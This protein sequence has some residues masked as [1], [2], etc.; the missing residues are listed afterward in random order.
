MDCLSDQTIARYVKAE[1]DAETSSLVEEHIDS[2]AS[3]RIAIAEAAR[4]GTLSSRTPLAI[5]ATLEEGPQTRL[6]IAAT[7]EEGPQT[8]SPTP[9]APSLSPGAQLGRYI[10]RRV[11]G[12]GAMG[13][14]YAAYDPNLERE[15]ALKLLRPEL[16]GPADARGLPER[17]L[18]EAKLM[19][20]LTHP[21]VISVYDVGVLDGQVFVA[22]ELVV[23]ETLRET[24]RK[25]RDLGQRSVKDVLALF[26]AAG[27]GLSA[28][29]R[30]HVV[31]R[32][33]KP[34]NVL[35]SQD[36]RV[37]VT[38]F[39]L[40]RVLRSED[41]G[42]GQAAPADPLR[43]SATHLTRTGAIVGT[44]AYMAPEQLH[45]QSA[46]ERSD[47][48]AFCVALYEGLYG[49]RPFAG[50]TLD[51]LAASIAAGAV[52]RDARVPAW[53]RR[54]VLRGLR[55]EP[56]E[57]WPSMDALISALAQNPVER[58]WRWGILT[59]LLLLIVMA[60]VAALRPRPQVRT[61]LGAAER[62]RGSWDSERRD[63][64]HR[65]FAATKMPYAEDAFAGVARSLDGYA[66]VWAAMHTEACEATW[67]RGE[68]SAELLDLRMQ[69]LEKQR[70]RLQA[71]VEVYTAPD[72]EG[73]RRA[74]SMAPSATELR[75]CAD[76]KE[77]LL[78]VRLPRD[79]AAR[80]RITAMEQRLAALRAR[81][82]AGQYQRGLKDAQLAATESAT[83]NYQ[84]VEAEAEL[85]LGDFQ[86]AV[87][88]LKEAES[89]F[90]RALW[91]GEAGKQDRISV[92]AWTRLA[93][94]VGYSQD[95]A[96]ESQRLLRHAQ[97][98]LQR[99]GGDD[100]EAATLESAAGSIAYKTGLYDEALRRFGKSRAL[101]EKTLGP[102][103]LEV[104]EVLQ[105]TSFA[106]EPSTQFEQAIALERQGLA[107]LIKRLGPE[108]PEV[109]AG[110]LRLG[111]H[112]RLNE[113]Y[114]SALFEM[115]AALSIYERSYP[116]DDIHVAAALYGVASVLVEMKQG[117]EAL[118]LAERA[119]AIRRQRLGPTHSDVAE[120]LAAHSAAL[121]QTGQSEQ[122]LVEA[123]QVQDLI[124]QTL[125]TNHFKYSF[126]LLDLG[127]I[128]F[129]RHDYQRALTTYRE[130]IAALRRSQVTDVWS[131]ARPQLAIAQVELALKQLPA[132]MARLEETR[133]ILERDDPTSLY[134]P[135]ACFQLAKLLALS[136]GDE[137][138][139]QELA[140]RALTLYRKVDFVRDQ[141]RV[142]AER[143]LAERPQAR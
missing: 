88:E 101:F 114:T 31:H 44:P 121:L 3:C 71:W 19:A 24:L 100:V 32:D 116:A 98:T 57:R 117:A 139:I 35:V 125:G 102:D 5:A 11:V 133:G 18:R 4:G 73:V 80:A 22:M 33:F 13:L 16:T 27:R 38:D 6:A 89:A 123:R 119:L 134:L 17:L 107:I 109:A 2:C 21:N 120:A 55:A 54:A 47:Q 129:A 61:C 42:P 1:I 104:A 122:A 87:G 8:R 74:V 28:A 9:A 10:V 50:S 110:R 90:Y 30:E 86:Q 106:L 97:A 128:Y 124:T 56:R 131:F 93:Y 84:P 138:R 15:V 37:Q 141:Q 91:A 112:L 52:P 82:Q 143:F 79:P 53:V 12:A 92:E 142:E 58:L 105:R 59:T 49:E 60:G 66:K 76:T 70:Q 48:F 69:C 43:I 130:S 137:A 132:A 95:R 113:F 81:F 41:P 23:G 126:A 99:L 7:L 115:R 29:H 51:A 65:A 64:V 127:Y 108:H 45:G 136:G 39:G 103:S 118:P 75:V 85:L 78:P 140:Q 63:A 135:D 14:V 111:E 25:R 94:L 46:D 34:D 26:L 40:A 20:R 67:L 83:L 96:P 72:I 62:L 77:L 36:G 68:Q